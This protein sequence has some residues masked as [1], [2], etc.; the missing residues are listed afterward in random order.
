M[1]WYCAKNQIELNWIEAIY[2]INSF[3]RYLRNA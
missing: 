2:L 1:S 3:S